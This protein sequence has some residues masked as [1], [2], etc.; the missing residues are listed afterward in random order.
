MLA[1]KGKSKEELKNYVSC[2]VKAAEKDPITGDVHGDGWGI[3]VYSDSGTLIH[4]RSSL[5]I[6]SDNKLWKILD[7]LEGQIWVIIH[8]RLA[9]QKEL[10]DSKFSHPYIE[11][12]PH[13]LLYF[14][15]NGSVDKFSLG[16]YL[17]IDP[18]FMVDSELIGKFLV[19]EGL[20]KESIDKL[21]EF[22]KSALNLFILRIPREK[23]MPQLLYVNFYNEDYVK[24]RGIPS[25]YY[26]L[27]R[28]ENVVFSSSLSYFCESGDEVMFGS[29]GEL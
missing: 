15:H 2:L 21:K 17:G 22:T 20:S 14:A 28:E 5:S 26:K 10:V 29:L 23:G 4:Y 3:V 27:Y 9:S 1:Y 7:I 16:K 19:R 6:F 11:S 18:Q 13:E 12:T 8:A 25:E 24:K